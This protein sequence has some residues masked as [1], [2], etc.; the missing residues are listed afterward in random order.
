MQSLRVAWTI[1]FARRLREM[2]GANRRQWRRRGES[3][4]MQPPDRYG[5]QQWDGEQFGSPRRN[6]RATRTGPV[7]GTRPR[8]AG[9]V[10]TAACP[11]RARRRAAA[12]DADFDPRWA[13]ARPCRVRCSRSR[14]SSPRSW[15]PRTSCRDHS[16]NGRFCRH[17][18]R[19]AGG[20]CGSGGPPADP[21][22]SDIPPRE[23][24]AI[25]FQTGADGSW[26]G[27]QR[28]ATVGR[29]RHARFGDIREFVEGSRHIRG[30]FRYNRQV[31]AEFVARDIA[32]RRSFP[33]AGAGFA[34][35]RSDD[36]R[37]GRAAEPP[38]FP[39][40]SSVSRG[41]PRAVRL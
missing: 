3:D 12:V 36:L 23:S 7:G 11:D 14:R 31:V 19:S 9:A 29:A 27:S 26:G 38:P 25:A 40:V 6:P 17:R 22:Y 33:G 20:M 34:Q 16:D 2:A 4:G 24:C 30:G 10:S 18:A 15:S 28:G 5:Y 41:R 1:S 21:P 35:R 32:A 37:E 39:P 13:T 8:F